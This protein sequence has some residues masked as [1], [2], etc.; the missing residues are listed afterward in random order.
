M[1][2]KDNGCCH[3]NQKDD[4]CTRVGANGKYGICW[5]QKDEGEY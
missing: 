5:M 2:C 1:W 4:K 3:Y